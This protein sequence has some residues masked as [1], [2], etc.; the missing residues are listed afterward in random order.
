MVRAELGATTPSR[1][2]AHR[3]RRRVRRQLDRWAVDACS[4]PRPRLTPAAQGG[5]HA[6]WLAN[7]GTPAVLRAARCRRLAAG[8]SAA[9]AGRRRRTSRPD[10]RRAT[11]AIVWRSMTGGFTRLRAPGRR[12]TTAA[13][14]CCR[15]SGQQQR[16][17]TNDH[18]RLVRHGERL[19]R[20][21]TPRKG[22][23]VHA[24]L[25]CWPLQRALLALGCRLA[26]RGG[27]ARHR[28]V[29][30]GTWPA[31]Q[32]SLTKLALVVLVH[33]LRQLPGGDAAVFRRT[34]PPPHRCHADG[35]GHGTWRPAKTMSTLLRQAHYR[36]AE[37][38]L[39]RW[40]GGGAAPCRQPAGAALRPMSDRLVP[41]QSVCW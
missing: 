25:P 30:A 20:C 22:I 13:V 15:N 17:T 34:A 37:R 19:L 29:G 31:L 38:L 41:G 26:G 4:A 12:A 5:Y 40:P 6:V 7:A 35:R 3:R 10:Q 9:A 24:L 23:H 16:A 2:S 1:C 39:P 21:G 27:P 8:R 11:L 32:S 14:S 33:Q 18:P 36:V 28:V